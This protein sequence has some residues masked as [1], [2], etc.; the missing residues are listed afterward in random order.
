MTSDAISSC[1]F[2]ASS[3]ARVIEVDAEGWA[4]TCN[5][6][7]GIG[8]VGASQADATEQWN[9]RHAMARNL[10]LLEGK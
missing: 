2:C 8:P 3:A 1:P 9:G 10:G 7:G 5:S 4:V 6:C